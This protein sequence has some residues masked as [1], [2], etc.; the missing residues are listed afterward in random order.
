MINF[1][2]NLVAGTVLTRSAIQSPN[3]VAGVSGWT[4]NQDGSAQ[5][6][7][8]SFLGLVFASN[9]AFDATNPSPN[10]GYART[11]Y[12]ALVGGYDSLVAPG[13]PDRT[14]MTLITPEYA[15]KP[16]MALDLYSQPGDG[17]TAASAKFYDT[18][19]ATH[20]T[21]SPTTVK[22][23]STFTAG[24]DSIDIGR[25]TLIN[26]ESNANSGVVGVA[27]A[28]ILTSSSATF[29]AN[30]AYKIRCYARYSQTTAAANNLIVAFRKTNLAGQVLSNIARFL[31][32]PAASTAFSGYVE[33]KFTVGAANVTAAI[34][35]TLVGSAANNA[36]QQAG[37]SFEIEDIGP[38]SL[39]TV[40]PVLV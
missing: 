30:R 31:Q 35:M 24:P 15:N 27:E 7:N 19:S 10:N 33:A 36:I 32:L 6:N 17:S 16:R 1:K 22:S 25:G 18:S 21:V 5:F 37:R 28:V 14:Y 40:E 3:Y 13:P 23:F 20:L 39:Y 4:I 9:I 8:V 2:S 34:A 38:S 29:R 12:G 11:A 26:A